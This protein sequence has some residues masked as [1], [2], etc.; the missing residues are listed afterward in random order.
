MLKI[1][2][3]PISYA[4]A[5]PLL[6]ALEGQLAP[7]AWRGALPISYHLGPGPAK[8]HLKIESDWSRKTV[9]DVIAKIRGAKNPDQWIVRGNH[10][11]GWV[12]GAAD[13]LTGQVALMSEAKAL[14]ACAQ[15]PAPTATATPAAGTPAVTAAAPEP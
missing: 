12:F 11:D 2:V 7:S 14:A 10:H 9:Y 13:P 8:V 6:A 1:P 15:T 3:L 5:Q 4:D